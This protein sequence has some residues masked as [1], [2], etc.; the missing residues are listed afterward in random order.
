MLDE[1]SWSFDRLVEDRDFQFV[2]RHY[3]TGTREGLRLVRYT[4]HR[5]G[6]FGVHVEPDI[7]QLTWLDGA[8]LGVFADQ[9]FSVIPPTQAMWI[10]AG[11]VHDIAALGPGTMYCA[12]LR[13]GIDRADFAAPRRVDVDDLVRGLLKHLVEDNGV[14]AGLRARAVL[15]DALGN[16]EAAVPSLRYPTHPVAR[17]VA[18][19]VA[20]EPGRRESLSEWAR[21]RGVSGRTLRRIFLAETGL[22]FQQWTAVARLTAALELLDSGMALDE[23]A[24]SV[25]FAGA[26]SFVPA[27]KKHFGMTPGAYRGRRR[28]L[29]EA[30]EPGA[31]AA[32]LAPPR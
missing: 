15:L 20:S 29:S 9:E 31:D 4:V 28:G 2:S 6:S 12:Y 8:L 7:H 21:A 17:A 13:V 22:T 26:S 10:P 3:R 16:A 30:S 23:V 24:R 1:S 11:T 32:G 27:F 19:R 25:G 18:D 5:E 14:E